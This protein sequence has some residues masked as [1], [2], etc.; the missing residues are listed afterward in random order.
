MTWRLQR[1]HPP[2]ALGQPVTWGEHALPVGGIEATKDGP[3]GAGALPARGIEAANGPE[4]AWALPDR[5][6]DA[7]NGLELGLGCRV[8]DR[9]RL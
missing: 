6:V 9:Q 7:A 5:S 1:C 3:E 4:S 2:V 8:S